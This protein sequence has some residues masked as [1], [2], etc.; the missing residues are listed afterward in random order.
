MDDI[1]IWRSAHL[2]IT[3]H[4]AGA[5]F[6]AAGRVDEMIAQGAPEGEATWKRILAAVRTL[7]GGLPVNRPLN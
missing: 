7:Q 3:Q 6:A 2:L 5:E 4:G 1:D